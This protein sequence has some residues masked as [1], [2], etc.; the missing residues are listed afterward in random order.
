MLLAIGIYANESFPNWESAETFKQDL[1][2]SALVANLPNM[3][4]ESHYLGISSS[5]NRVS[6]NLDETYMIPSARISIYPN[7]GYN[8]WTQFSKWP[9]DRP[10]F[11]VGTGVQVEFPSENPIQR[12]AIGLSWNEVSTEDYL[13]R[14]ISIHGLFSWSKNTLNYGCMAI[15]DLHHVLIEDQFG[16][17]DYDKT[18]YQVVPYVNWMVKEQLKL[19]MALPID[20]AGGTLSIGAEYHIGKRK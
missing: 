12:R 5:L 3:T 1:R 18:L 9:G 15:I 7:P 19:T 4:E 13:Q 6:S 11:S 2:A 16:I 14:D 20:A 8:I 17:P 10:R